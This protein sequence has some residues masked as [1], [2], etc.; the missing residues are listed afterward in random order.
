MSTTPTRAPPDARAPAARPEEHQPADQCGAGIAPGC[1]VSLHLEVRFEDGFVALST[2]GEEPLVCRIGDGTLTPA[3]EATLLGLE[4]GSETHIIGHGSELFSPYDESNVHWLA[5]D[6]FPS[7]IEPRPGLVVAF[8]TPGGYET[9][10]V[11]KRVEG[12]QVEVDF[13]HPFAGHSLTIRVQV[14]SVT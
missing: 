1:S 9:G 7:P 4:P 14:L 6:D 2:L 11:I 10:G 5:R 13:N 8:E 3:F 12:E